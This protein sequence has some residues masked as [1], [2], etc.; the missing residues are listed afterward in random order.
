MGGELDIMLALESLF[1]EPWM[2]HRVR[3]NRSNTNRLSAF[4][5]FPFPCLLIICGALI[6]AKIKRKLL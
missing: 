5:L 1:F 3:E 2:Q 6:S 4:N